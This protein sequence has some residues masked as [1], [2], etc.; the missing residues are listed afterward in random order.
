MRLAGKNAIVTGAAHGIG[1]AIAEVFA[2]NGA[3]VLICDVDESAGEEV[4]AGIRAKG[5]VASFARVDVSQEDQVRRAVE[6]VAQS[7]NG[8]IDVLCNNAAWISD[9]HNV[10]EASDAEWQKCIA[11]SLMGTT[12]FMR[13]ALPHM[14]P[15]KAGSIIN[16]ASIQGIV[17]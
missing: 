6:V 12:Y 17:G 10:V 13:H 16:I 2:E 5:Q 7:S 4:A 14:S 15:H 8:R 9:W 1:R 3:R 11:V